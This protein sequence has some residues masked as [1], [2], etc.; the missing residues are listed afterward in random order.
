ML[1]SEWAFRQVEG[2]P[3]AGSVCDVHVSS[4][5]CHVKDGNRAKLDVCSWLPSANSKLLIFQYSQPPAFEQR[6]TSPQDSCLV[7]LDL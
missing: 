2:F 6:E 1:G 7:L 5:S 4:M 3:A